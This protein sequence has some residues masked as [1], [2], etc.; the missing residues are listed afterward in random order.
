MDMAMDT[1]TAGRRMSTLSRRTLVRWKHSARL[2]GVLLQRLRLRRG[3]QQAKVLSGRHTPG[4]RLSNLSRGLLVRW[5]HSAR[6]FGVDGM[7]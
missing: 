2:F 7:A 6:L 5:K 3:V 4:R 1:I